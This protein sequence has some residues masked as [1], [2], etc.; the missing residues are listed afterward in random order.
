M[1]KLEARIALRGGRGSPQK[2]PQRSRVLQR[3]QTPPPNVATA[4]STE[5]GSVHG[6]VSRQTKLYASPAAY[7]IA[8][9]QTDT[10]EQARW[11]HALDTSRER[12]DRPSRSKP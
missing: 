3:A 6:P 9:S 7:V 12:V 10:M 11:M 1:G 4:G 5:V 2:S 8:L